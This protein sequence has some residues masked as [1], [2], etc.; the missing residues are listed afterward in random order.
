[1]RRD[2]EIADQDVAVVAA[3]MQ[4]LAGLHLVEEFQLVIELRIERGI[5]NVAAGR[6]VEIMQHQRF[7][8]LRLLA[9]GHGDVARIHLVAEGPD[10]AALERQL[11]DDGDAVIAL[12]PV[13]RDVLIAEPLEALARKGVVDAFRLLQAQHVRPRRLHEFGDEIDAQPHRID[14]PGCQGE[15]HGECV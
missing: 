12:L 13:Q 11:R 1:M 15:T 7:C 5:G 9:E 2:V 8:K 14:V 3:R 10:V 6:H 4:R